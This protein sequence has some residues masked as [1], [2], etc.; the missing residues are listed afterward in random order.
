MNNFDLNILKILRSFFSLKGN[1]SSLHDISINDF[2]SGRN[3]L[4]VLHNSKSYFGEQ[5]GFDNNELINYE[6]CFYVLVRLLLNKLPNEIKNYEDFNDV[7]KLDIL[8]RLSKSNYF[9]FDINDALTL[10][11]INHLWEESIVIQ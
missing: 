3:V 8:M 6:R 10:E 2:L 11:L 7:I 9:D 5:L 1:L 4:R